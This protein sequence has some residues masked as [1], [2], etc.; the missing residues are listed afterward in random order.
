M[1]E[2]ATMSPQLSWPSRVVEHSESRGYQPVMEADNVAHTILTPEESKVSDEI[3][4]TLYSKL[5]IRFWVKTELTDTCW[6]WLGAKYDGNYG[7]FYWQHRNRRPH[8]LVWSILFGEMPPDMM[9]C[10]KCDNPPCFNPSHLFLGTNADN[11]A[12]ANRKGRHGWR[13]HPL[14][15]KQG[16]EVCNAGFT[17]S[18]VRE[19]KI[20]LANGA[21]IKEVARR[22]GIAEYTI[23]RIKRGE[24]W[25][26]IK[27]EEVKE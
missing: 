19:I 5:P 14:T 12:D 8:R 3:R 23:R 10:H 20:E 1:L 27:I 17:N 26:H 24:N 22:H 13:T 4:E 18:Q 25:A 7:C 2:H 16:E 21:S 9:V 11:Q 6:I 15:R